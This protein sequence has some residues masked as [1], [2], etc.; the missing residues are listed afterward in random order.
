MGSSIWRLL[1]SGP[2]DPYY[3]MALDEALMFCYPDTGFPTLRFYEWQGMAVSIGYFQPKKLIE[4]Q[5]H[6]TVPY[7]IV[8]RPTGGG[9]VIHDNDITFSLIFP[10][11]LLIGSIINS[12][13]QI[14]DAI[15]TAMQ[16]KAPLSLLDSHYRSSSRHKTPQFCFEEPSKY[17][18]LWNDEKV[19]GSAQRRKNGIVLHQASFYYQKCISKSQITPHSPV[20]SFRPVFRNLI[21]DGIARLFDVSFSE[22][23]LTDHEKSMADTLFNTRYSSSSWNDKR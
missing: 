12:Y 2:A 23:G 1:I 9:A 16:K 15:I 13:F 14:N 5:T 4:E 20:E 22:I 10:C 21:Q 6:L 11:H 18:I 8:R 7:R 3:N 19:G 17:D